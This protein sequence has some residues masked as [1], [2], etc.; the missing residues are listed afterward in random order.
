MDE[1]ILLCLQHHKPKENQQA[2]SNIFI[3]ARISLLLCFS[4]VFFLLF[5]MIIE[6][7]PVCP[8]QMYK[9]VFLGEA[10]GVAF[11]AHI[12]IT[13]FCYYF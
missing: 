5:L 8:V 4:F 12:Y 1:W 11:S 3:L 2:E 6:N 9:Q 7:V 13:K 10:A